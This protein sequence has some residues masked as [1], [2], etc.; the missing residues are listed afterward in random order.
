MQLPDRVHIMEVGP[1]DGFQAEHEWI[2]TE[3]KIEIVNALSKT[4]IPEIQ[5]TS[6]P[7]PTWCRRQSPTGWIAP[8]SRPASAP[9]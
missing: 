2:P 8:C 1:R 7:C 3:K 5:V 6:W 9:T 4:G